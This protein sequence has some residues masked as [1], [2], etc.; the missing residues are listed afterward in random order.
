MNEP[1]DSS[2][3]RRPGHATEKERM[4]PTQGARRISK[5]AS[6]AVISAAEHG[7]KPHPPVSRRFVS[8]CAT[9]VLAILIMN[10]ILAIGQQHPAPGYAI[11]GSALFGLAFAAF[12]VAA[13]NLAFSDSRRQH[14]DH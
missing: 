7:P 12:L 2:F 10:G 8:V 14:D 11:F 4:N 3:C 6:R 1:P 5:E 9:F 13:A